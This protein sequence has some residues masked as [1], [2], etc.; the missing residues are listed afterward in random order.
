MDSESEG[1]VEASSR[2]NKPTW[3]IGLTKMVGIGTW[4]PNHDQGSLPL[5]PAHSTV[6]RLRQTTIRN[7]ITSSPL[8][9][10]FCRKGHRVG[11]QAGCDDEARWGKKPMPPCN[12]VDMLTYPRFVGR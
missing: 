12:G 10:R 11:G 2:W 1:T 5:N 3:V 7:G 6:L 4:Q 9:I 8:S